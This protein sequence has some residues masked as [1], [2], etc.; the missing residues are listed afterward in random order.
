ML[1]V[2]L[3]VVGPTV[4]I[5]GTFTNSMGDYLTQ[6]PSMSFSAG[7]F[8]GQDWINPWTIFYW[9]W[10]IWTPFVGMFIARISKAARSGGSSS[11]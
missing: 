4:F 9:A 1:L 7:V 8:G 10:W 2:F 6:L 3:F 11:T 5:L